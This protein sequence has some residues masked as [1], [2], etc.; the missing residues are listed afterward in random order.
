M[1]K[2]KCAVIEDENVNNNRTK[3]MFMIGFEKA[4]I[5]SSHG[6]K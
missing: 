3:N 2:E 4:M 1:P 6:C 5:K